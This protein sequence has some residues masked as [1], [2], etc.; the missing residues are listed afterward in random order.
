MADWLRSHGD[1]FSYLPRRRRDRHVRSARDQF[2][3]PRQSAA[4]GKSVLIVPGDHF[5][6]DGY[7]RIGFGEEVGYL[8]EGLTRLHDLLV[9]LGS[10][11][12]DVGLVK[13]D[14]S[15]L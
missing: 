7:L 9:D 4:P 11:I 13:S 2:D 5:G 3:S 14:S 15:A 1:R 6:M 10:G 8:R 12:S